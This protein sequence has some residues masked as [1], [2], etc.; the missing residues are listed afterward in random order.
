MLTLADLRDSFKMRQCNPNVWLGLRLVSYAFRSVFMNTG[1]IEE[2]SMNRM[3]GWIRWSQSE[4]F[5]SK[6]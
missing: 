2:V 6:L 4:F 5:R 3:H 1:E